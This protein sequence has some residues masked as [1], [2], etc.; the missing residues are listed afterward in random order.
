MENGFDMSKKDKKKRDFGAKTPEQVGKKD[1]QAD[2]DMSPEAAEEKARVA[3][4][5]ALF[6]EPSEG[7]DRDT[8]NP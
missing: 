1:V 8:D 3:R 4:I 6:Y 5:R 2:I 7:P